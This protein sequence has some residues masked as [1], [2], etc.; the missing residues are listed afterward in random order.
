[1]NGICGKHAVKEYYS[2]TRNFLTMKFTTGVNDKY[3]YEYFEAVITPYHRGK[4]QYRHR[5]S[6]IL[7]ANAWVSKDV[8][9]TDR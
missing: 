3:K 9:D 5:D 4:I 2:T 7:H 6:S 8:L 1:M